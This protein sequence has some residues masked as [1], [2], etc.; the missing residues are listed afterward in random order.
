MKDEKRRMVIMSSDL[1][2]ESFKVL[3]ER[4]FDMVY[5]ICFM[6]LKNEADIGDANK[7]PDE[8]N[9]KNQ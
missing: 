2:S 7:I 1:P 6:Y 8:L 3:Y 9:G 4:H 5:K